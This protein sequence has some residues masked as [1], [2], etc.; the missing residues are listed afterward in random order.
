[1]K[2][3]KTGLKRMS[4][5]RGGPERRELFAEKDPEA[6]RAKFRRLREEETQRKLKVGPIT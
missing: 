6:I 1:V 4:T 5:G 3:E 2:R